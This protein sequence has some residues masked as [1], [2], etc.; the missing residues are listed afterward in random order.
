MIIIP[1]ESFGPWPRTKT[2]ECACKKWSPIPG[3]FANIFLWEV[4]IRT[5]AKVRRA[6][7]GL[8][9]DIVAILYTTALRKGPPCNAAE[10]FLRHL[11][12]RM[13]RLSCRPVGNINYSTKADS[14]NQFT[15]TWKDTPWTTIG[16]NPWAAPHNSEHDHRKRLDM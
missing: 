6:E 5:F 3:I 4:Q 15:N 1:G 8:R 14:R 2:T 7:F 16:I 11:P 10:R 13:P 9:G 12:A